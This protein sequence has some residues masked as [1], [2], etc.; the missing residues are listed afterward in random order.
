MASIAW[1][2]LGNMG[3]P[4]AANLVRAGHSVTGYDMSSAAIE[5]AAK[6]GVVIAE[7]IQDAVAGADFVFT[8]LPNGQ[9]VADVY[10]QPGGVFDSAKPS[11][12][13]VDSS[14][15]DI[16]S[17]KA[18]H[19]QAQSRK[20]AFLDAPVSGGTVGAEAATL[21]FMVGGSSEVLEV[22]HPIIDAMSKNIF[23]CGEA[24]MGQAAKI[25]NNMILF[26]TLAATAE[27]AVLA[28]RLGLD[29]QVFW[30]L[31]SV[32]SADSWA[33]R[34]WYPISGPVPNSAANR[35]FEPTFTVE[36]AHKD[37]NLALQAGEDSGTPLELAEHVSDLFQRLISEGL[38][39]KDCSILSKL[40]DG[41]LNNTD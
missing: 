1:I 25:A 16:A 27:G 35:D 20:L 21:T 7:T 2:G 31:A 14:T 13:M 3:G 6:T 4:M 18:L 32:S 8:M 30:D 37:V 17:S 12:V 9:I 34:T 11:A 22:A 40:V 38:G 28:D 10:T 19:A 39:K 29:R 36:L 41:S 23:Y 24:S 15:I 33:L 26:I 5:Q